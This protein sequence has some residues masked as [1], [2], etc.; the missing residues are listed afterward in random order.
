MRSR[1]QIVFASSDQIHHF[2]TLPAIYANGNTI[3][4]ALANAPQ[5][6]RSAGQE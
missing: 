5:A 2:T 3:E 1:L 4:M 6:S